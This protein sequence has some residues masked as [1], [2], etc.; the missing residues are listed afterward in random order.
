MKAAIIL[1]GLSAVAFAL[2]TPDGGILRL[3]N[4]LTPEGTF[5]YG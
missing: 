2:P 5:R 4:V 3:E 1:F